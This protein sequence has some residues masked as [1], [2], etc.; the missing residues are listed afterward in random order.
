MRFH[1]SWGEERSIL[2][3]GGKPLPRRR[4]L[5]TLKGDLEGKAQRGQY[6]LA[7]GLSYYRRVQGVH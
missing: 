5:K 7:V 6:L 4:I 1:F 3:K 2:Y